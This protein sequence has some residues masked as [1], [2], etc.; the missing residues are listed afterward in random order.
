[1]AALS[2][3]TDLAIGQ[4]VEFALQSCVLGLRL[5]GEL[6]C[7][8]PTLREIYHQ[9]LLRYIGCNAGTEALSALVGDEFEFRRLVVPRDM[10][11]P[12]SS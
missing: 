6:G 7:D 12:S 11:T 9:A 10:K 1:M 5:G 4:P 3:A 8:G 2:H